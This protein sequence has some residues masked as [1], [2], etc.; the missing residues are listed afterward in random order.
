VLFGLS[1]ATLRRVE[2]CRSPQ[3]VSRH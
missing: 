1:A 3:R 2:F